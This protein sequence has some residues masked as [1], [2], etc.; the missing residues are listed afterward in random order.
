MISSTE[1]TKTK[2]SNDKQEGESDAVNS[3]KGTDKEA[4]ITNEIVQQADR[5]KTI[6]YLCHCI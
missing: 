5:S 2:I 3:T 4:S 6:D 1:Q